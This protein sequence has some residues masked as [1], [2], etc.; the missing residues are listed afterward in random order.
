MSAAL[1]AFLR[2]SGI[3]DER[4]LAAIAQIPRDRFVPESA[5]DDAEADRPLPIG[6]GQTISQPYVAA[7]MTESLRLSGV[8]RVLE[9][10]TGSGYQTALLAYLAE[11]VFSIEIVAELSQRARR[12]LDELGIANVHLRT[13]DGALGWPQ[14]APFDRIIVTAA[15]PEV[16]RDLMDQLAAGGRM[17]IPVGEDLDVQ[18]LRVIDKGNDGAHV[19]ANLLPV[20]F[21]PLT[22]DV[23]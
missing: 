8:E 11:E 14:E 3:R 22:H 1:A 21:V 6:F 15:A 18:W 13:G 7:Y 16:P 9:V 2:H 10:G 23:R 20:R 17:I 4:V 5:R 12:V 19:E